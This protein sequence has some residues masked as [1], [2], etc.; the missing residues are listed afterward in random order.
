MSLLNNKEFVV[1]GKKR[2]MRERVIGEEVVKWGEGR[3]CKVL[4]D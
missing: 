4:W 1:V 2:I 3:L